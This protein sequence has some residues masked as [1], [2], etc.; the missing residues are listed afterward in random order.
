[1]AR[2]GHGPRRGV[3]VRACRQF[4]PERLPIPPGEGRPHSFVR[5]RRDFREI[6]AAG[7]DE[8]SRLAAGSDLDASDDAFDAEGFVPRGETLH[9]STASSAQRIAR[10]SSR[11]SSPSAPACPAR[12]RERW[13]PASTSRR[14]APCSSVPCPR[15]CPASPS[16]PAT[17]S[18]P[19]R[20][21]R[22]SSSSPSSAA[23]PRT[24]GGSTCQ[25]LTAL[26]GTTNPPRYAASQCWPVFR[27]AVPRLPGRRATRGQRGDARGR[28]SPGAGDDDRCH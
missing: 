25:D 8:I 16:S 3:A 15:S 9:R 17:W 28:C 12:R 26:A 18:L 1:M 10:R 21:R 20:S 4:G 5:R 23:S 14:L 6:R 2:I 24:P 11:R 22:P 27:R 7:S 19:P 13:S